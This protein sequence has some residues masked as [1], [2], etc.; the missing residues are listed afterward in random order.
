M[1]QRDGH[2]RRTWADASNQQ[3]EKEKQQQQNH[4]NTTCEYHKDVIS[5]TQLALTRLCFEALFSAKVGPQVWRRRS[6]TH[7]YSIAA[8]ERHTHCPH[9]SCSAVLLPHYAP[10]HWSHGEEIITLKVYIET[11]LFCFHQNT[12][13]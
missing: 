6:Q 5:Y 3:T 9:H 12:G 1:V 13:K 7:H 4:N 10:G 8:L 11:I 2:I